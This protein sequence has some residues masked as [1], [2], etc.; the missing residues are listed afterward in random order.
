MKPKT[1]FTRYF[2]VPGEK[3][4][5]GEKYFN[6]VF[7]ENQE[8]KRHA[9]HIR[10]RDKTND[11]VFKGNDQ[12]YVKAKLFLCSRDIQVGDKIQCI[13]WRPYDCEFVKEFP[14][15]NIQIKLPDGQL[16][17]TDYK[18]VYKVI[19][20]ISPDATWV[21]EGAEFD[22][23]QLAFNSSEN[24]EIFLM[25]F[26]WAQ[27]DSEYTGLIYIKGSDGQFR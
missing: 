5:Y 8:R 17:T 21:K 1:F 14:N 2:P 16:H 26:D 18:E 22:E 7:F 23:K 20:E 10:T 27:P 4:G 6:K 12:Y 24:D 3:I 9:I 15:G 11:D 25:G 13:G 19:G